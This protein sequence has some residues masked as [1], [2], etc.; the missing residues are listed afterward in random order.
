[1]RGEERIEG[2]TKDAQGSFGIMD[3]FTVF[4]VVKES[5]VHIP[6]TDFKYVHF[7]VCHLYLHKAIF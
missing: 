7:L 4:I 3:M 1:M 5:Q 6:Y 2:I